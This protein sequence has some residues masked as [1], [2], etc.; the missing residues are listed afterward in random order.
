MKALLP[1][2]FLLGACSTPPQ[3]QVVKD[4]DG[5]IRAEVARH[6]GRKHGPVR[7][8]GQNGALT[9]TG[10]YVHDSRD[11]AWVTTGPKGDTLSIVTFN[12]GRKDGLQAYWASNGQLLRMERFEA[13]EPNGELYRFFADGSPR[14]ITWY[15]HGTPEGPYLEWYKVDSTSIA[16]TMGQFHNGER[17]GQWTWFYGNGRVQRQ[18]HY[19]SG[20]AKGLWRWWDPQGRLQR[21]VDHSRH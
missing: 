18:G 11:G 19:A 15:D 5:R 12:R 21:Q 1:L 8:F 2:I 10:S 16:L 7:F 17:T 14:Q 6:A 9:T 20:Q 4:R 3:M 13:G